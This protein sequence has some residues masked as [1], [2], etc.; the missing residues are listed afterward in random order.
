MKIA[1]VIGSP[2][3]QSLSPAIHNAAFRANGDEW[4]YGSFHVASGHVQEALSAMREFSISG[5]SVTMPHKD[6]AFAA[7]E[8]VH[9]SAQ[10]CRSVNTVLLSSDGKLIGANT[11]GDG[12]CDALEAAG[13]SISGAR[14]VVVGAGGT[15]RAVITAAA[16]R[17][18]I[19][20]A[21]VNRSSA[22]A[23]AAASLCDAAHV[24]RDGDISAANIVINTT[25]V[26]MGA[27]AKNETPI[28]VVQLRAQQYV[29][30]AVYYPLLTPLLRAAQDCGAV[31]VDGLNMLVH[32][33]SLQQFLWLGRAADVSVMRNA[34]LNEIE[35][36]R[37]RRPP[38][39]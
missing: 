37:A 26:G 13:G 29:L 27:I 32:Q 20:I 19:D 22:S 28:D 25:P 3:S 23:I 33:A 10:E 35:A 7:V 24:A 34:A 14:I 5:L 16:K 31:A 30:D 38:I 4:A 2:I 36:R 6:A 9:D 15:A 11:D 8:G 18:A 1:A 12:C 17:G 39:A 21:I